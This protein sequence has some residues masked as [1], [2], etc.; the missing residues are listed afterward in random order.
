MDYYVSASTPGSFLPSRNS[1]LAP[2]PVEMCVI[3]S[4]TPAWLIAVTESPP[5]MIDVALLFAATAFAM[6][7]VPTAKRGNSK[8]PAGPFHTIVR[9]FA[10]ICSIAA[11]DFGPMSSPCQSAGKFF[12]LS[13]GW[14]L[15]S[16]AKFVGEHVVDRQQQIHALGL[17]LGE[18]FLRHVDLV[19][20]NERFAGRDAQRALEGVG[21]AAND[22][23]GVDLVEQI[24]DHVDLAG[25]LRAANDGDERLLGD[26]RA[27]PR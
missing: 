5:P 12:D 8:T 16:L 4:A 6:A 21:H 15:A 9:P 19:F 11:T 10:I 24:L 27:L 23:Q 20:F 17:R 22:D 25:D 14:V 18:R 26:S 7:L 2:P 3:W 13:H 1:S